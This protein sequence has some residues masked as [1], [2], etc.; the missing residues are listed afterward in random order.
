MD[1]IKTDRTTLRKFGFLMATVLAL[2]GLIIFTKHE[3]SVSP[4]AVMAL[5]FMLIAMS[6]AIFAPLLLKYPYILWMRLA[7]IL[8]WVNTRLLLGVIFYLV[9]SPVGLF[10]RLFR[11]DLLERDPEPL[12]D[13]YWKP[14]AGKRALPDDYR[15]QS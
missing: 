2:I 15:R 7:Y 13:S 3:Y 6:I 9:F 10:R 8:S 11:I 12:N 5:S 1:K 4:T 14:K